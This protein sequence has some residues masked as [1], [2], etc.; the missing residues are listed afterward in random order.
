LE[1]PKTYTKELSTTMP[2]VPA[3]R[4]RGKQIL[5]PDQPA[6][7]PSPK[8]KLQNQQESLSQKQQ[9]AKP[10]RITNITLLGKKK[11]NKAKQTTKQNKE[12]K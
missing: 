2:V 9:R 6:H 11:K 12:S 8:E 5:G 4:G 10:Y 3:L 1:I 7:L